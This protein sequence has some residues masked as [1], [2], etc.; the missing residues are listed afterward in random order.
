MME[1]TDSGARIYTYFVLQSSAY[2]ACLYS[3]LIFLIL[4]FFFKHKP[5]PENWGNPNE[6][7]LETEESMVAW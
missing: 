6:T 5:H 3:A 4:R 2:D 1:L 7:K